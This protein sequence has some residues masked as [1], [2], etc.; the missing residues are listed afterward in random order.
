MPCKM[1][2]VKTRLLRLL[3]MQL[4]DHGPRPHPH[5]FPK[6]AWL[7]KYRPSL[8]VGKQG[9]ASLTET[10]CWKARQNQM[11]T[12][13]FRLCPV[14]ANT[15]AVLMVNGPSP[16]RN[17]TGRGPKLCPQRSGKSAKKSKRIPRSASPQSVDSDDP[18]HRTTSRHR[19]VSSSAIYTTYD[20]P[21]LGDVRRRFQTLIFARDGSPI[22]TLTILRVLNFKLALLAAKDVMDSKMYRDFK[23]AMDIAF[24]DTTKE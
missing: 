8:S 10:R 21:I 20:G 11:L 1:V 7:M 19:P 3:L 12:I 22:R 24:K 23:H 15:A 4:P 18:D 6:L 13:T 9:P 16:P 5:P 14:Q 17:L 2:M